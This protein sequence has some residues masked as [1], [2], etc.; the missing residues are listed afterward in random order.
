LHQTETLL[1]EAGAI[2]CDSNAAAA[3]LTGMIVSA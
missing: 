3:Q 1:E 2:L